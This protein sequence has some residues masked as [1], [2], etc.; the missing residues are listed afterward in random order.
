MICVNVAL[1][2]TVQDA[3]RGPFYPLAQ[4]LQGRSREPARGALDAPVR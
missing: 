4:G 2:P 1:R 3:T